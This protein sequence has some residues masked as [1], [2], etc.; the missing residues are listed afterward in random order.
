MLRIATS[1]DL[2]GFGS[3]VK[4]HLYAKGPTIRG[5]VERKLD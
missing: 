2:G 3:R 1:L 5:A 4:L